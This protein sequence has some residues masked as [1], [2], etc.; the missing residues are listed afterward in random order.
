MKDK[1]KKFGVENI[2]I[3]KEGAIEVDKEMNLKEVTNVL[4]MF[5]DAMNHRICRECGGK[6]KKR[7][8]RCKIVYF[9]SDECMRLGW[10]KYHKKECKK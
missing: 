10:K 9:C 2:R 4:S 7:C 1:F 3:T 8:T 6:T 5:S